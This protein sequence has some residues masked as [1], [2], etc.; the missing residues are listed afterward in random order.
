MHR[1]DGTSIVYFIRNA[2]S[3]IYIGWTTQI[4]ERLR[5]GVLL[6]YIPGGRV[7]CKAIEQKFAH[8]VDYLDNYHD[9]PELLEFIADKCS[10]PPEPP[11]PALP[12]LT[13]P[14]YLNA[15]LRILRALSKAWAR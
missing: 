14:A 6:G 5:D 11:L 9:D 1:L 12:R 13:R 7:E 8:L 3:W 15:A 2:S 10:R 4:S